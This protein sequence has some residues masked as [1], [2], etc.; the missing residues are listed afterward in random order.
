[1]FKD[2][3][4]AIDLED[5]STWDRAAPKAVSLAKAF[6]ADLHVMAV[7]P[8]FGM[9]LVASFFPKDFEKKALD[10]ANARLHAWVSENIPPGIKVQHIV[11]H[12]RAYEEIMRIAG[13]IPCDL[14]IL[15]ARRT[16]EGDSYEVGPNTAH[17]VR[18][19]NHSVLIV[20]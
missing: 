20:R 2:I 6:G 1:M 9:T 12:G 17:I 18:H 11:G 5:S 14:L 8:D 13:D 15:S 19:T 4:L 3:L 10:E 7:V 16:D